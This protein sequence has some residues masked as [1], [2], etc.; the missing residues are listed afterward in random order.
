ME[1][2]TPL[3]QIAYKGD[4]V[5]VGPETLRTQLLGELAAEALAGSSS[6]LYASLYR[7]GLVNSAFS[8]G[9]ELY[10]GCVFL[11]AGGESRDPEEVARRLGEEAVRLAR[12]G[13]D[14]GL[15]NRLKKAAYGSRVRALNS[16]ENICV[17][18]AQNFFAGAEAFA[19]PEA[20]DRVTKQDAEQLLAR[21]VTHA[22]TT[23]SVVRPKGGE[24]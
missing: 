12:E 15:W 6:P 14:E 11:Y 2:S 19:F 3:F 1:V 13:I 22:R 9:C 4:P 7:Q 8:C 16:F 24:A 10:P 21:W 17:G 5:P 20:F 23:L 18:Q